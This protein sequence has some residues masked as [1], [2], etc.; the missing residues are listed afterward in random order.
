[1]AIDKTVIRF[2]PY[3]AG[4]NFG[5][6]GVRRTPTTGPD[7]IA[8]AAFPGKESSAVL[9]SVWMGG[10]SNGGWFSSV[11]MQ[12]AGLSGAVREWEFIPI[13]ADG[14]TLT[15]LTQADA[16]IYLGVGGDNYLVYAGGVIEVGVYVGDVYASIGS[17]DLGIPFDWDSN[18]RYDGTYEVLLNWSALP[19][20]PAF[21]TALKDS[22]ETS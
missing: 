15:P 4:D 20:A 1:M 6:I 18:W 14:L 11:D 19:A 21:W 9:A 3:D 12:A 7:G 5:M 8:T 2:L 13:G 16:V 10:S 17:A 22:I